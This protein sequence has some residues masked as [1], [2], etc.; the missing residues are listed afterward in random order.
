[1][2]GIG[3]RE[4]ERGGKKEQEI[5]REGRREREKP[6]DREIQV[7]TFGIVCERERQEIEERVGEGGQ[8]NLRQE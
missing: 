5:D 6:I 4:R 7:N 3:E 2:R 1:M 8:K